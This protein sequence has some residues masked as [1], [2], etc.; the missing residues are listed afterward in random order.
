[1][2]VNN[3]LQLYELTQIYR[4]NR[5]TELLLVYVLIKYFLQLPCPSTFSTQPSQYPVIR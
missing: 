3:K 2:G 1:M 5:A 4:Q